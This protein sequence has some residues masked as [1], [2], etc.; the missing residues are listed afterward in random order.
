MYGR[1]NVILLFVVMFVSLIFKVDACE[2]QGMDPV[3]YRQ[4][5]E[6]ACLLRTLHHKEEVLLLPNAWDALSAKTFEK[7]GAKAIATTSAG[8]A[9]VFGY[10]DGKLPKDLLL[11]MIERIVK[12]VSVPVTVDLESGY[13]D[14]PEEVCETVLS[15]LKIGAVGINIEDADPKQPGHL[16]SI[17]EQ[18]E[19][20]RAIK[21]LANRVNLPLFINARTDVFWQN[22]LSPEERLPETLRRLEA[23]KEAGADGV[24]VPG[25][26]DSDLISEVSKTIE[27]PLNVLA[28]PWMKEMAHVKQLG[29]ARL[30]MG[31][32]GA[33]ESASHLKRFAGQYLEGHYTLNPMI[34]YEELSALFDK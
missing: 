8:M 6:K 29:V 34:S 26:T 12:S 5:Y 28:G 2:V 32:S 31:S 22:L 20:I 21:S 7:A 10:A 11:L 9:S 16:F 30:T 1:N 33:R 17:T 15:I 27:L 19:K 24:F 18:V 3:F 13:G 23:Y 4:L 25:L 14:T